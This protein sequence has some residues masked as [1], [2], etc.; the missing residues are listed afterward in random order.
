MFREARLKTERA[1]RYPF[2][3]PGRWYTAAAAAGLV[4]A[5]GPVQVEVERHARVR[6]LHPEDFEF[7]GGTPRVGWVGL[8]TRRIDRR[9]ASPHRAAARGVV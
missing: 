4:K 3:R 2:L 7:R 1:E 5:C 8:G 6:V 9:D